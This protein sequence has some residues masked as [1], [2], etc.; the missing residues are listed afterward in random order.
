MARMKPGGTGA[1][2]LCRARGERYSIHIYILIQEGMIRGRTGI[3][4]R[5][6]CPCGSA[7]PGESSGSDSPELAPPPQNYTLHSTVY[8]YIYEYVILSN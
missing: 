2:R 6:W 1:P 4:R 7:A 3:A 8:V 5:G